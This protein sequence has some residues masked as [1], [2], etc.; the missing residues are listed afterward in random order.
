MGRS[1]IH[2]VPLPVSQ[3]GMMGASACCCAAVMRLPLWKHHAAYASIR[4]VKRWRSVRLSL[5]RLSNLS[6]YQ[7]G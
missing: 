7:P 3:P 2:S 1:Y 5:C 4:G 6:S